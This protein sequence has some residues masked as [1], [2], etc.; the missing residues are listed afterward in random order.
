MMQTNVLPPS[1]GLKMDAA[2]MSETSIPPMKLHGFFSFAVYFTILS[3]SRPYSNE[4][5]K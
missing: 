4:C 3:V 2:G 5:Y 1:L